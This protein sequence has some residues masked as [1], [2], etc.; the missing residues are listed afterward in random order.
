MT[1][2]IKKLYLLLPSIL[3]LV[4]ITITYVIILSSKQ[5]LEREVQGLKAEIQTMKV[6][7]LSDTKQVV[8]LLSFDNRSNLIDRLDL[9]VAAFRDNRCL[10][11]TSPSPRD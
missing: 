11:Y 4:V 8:K 3:C 10:L 5:S 1:G 7:K 6:S 2:K 9:V